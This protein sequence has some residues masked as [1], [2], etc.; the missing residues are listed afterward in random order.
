MEGEEYLKF[1]AAKC[2]RL[3]NAISD[4]PMRESLNSSLKS[5]INGLA[6]NNEESD[7]R[8]AG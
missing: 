7:R 4:G 8:S 1:M 5:T 3:A 6:R 2:R